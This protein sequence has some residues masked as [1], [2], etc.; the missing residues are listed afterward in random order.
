ML[1]CPHSGDTIKYAERGVIADKY[2]QRSLRLL[3][4]NDIV[5]PNI[6]SQSGPIQFKSVIVMTRYLLLLGHD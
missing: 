2:S 1:L 3:M 6:G 4:S 5:F